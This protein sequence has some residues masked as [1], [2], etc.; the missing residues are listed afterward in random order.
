MRQGAIFGCEGEIQ[1]NDLH[2][3]EFQGDVDLSMLGPDPVKFKG[4]KVKHLSKSDAVN[5]LWGSFP[6]RA[7]RYG[8]AWNKP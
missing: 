8:D 5:S 6:T 2:G 3:L 1:F 4:Y 7:I